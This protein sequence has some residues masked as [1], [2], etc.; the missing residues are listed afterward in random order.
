M[1]FT[2]LS[3]LIGGALAATLPI[4][5]HLLSKGAPKRQV[6]PAARFVRAKL[7]ANKRRLTLKRL[8]LLAVRVAMILLLGLTLSRPYFAH[9][10]QG[11][12]ILEARSQTEE[13][14]QA[15]Q[16][17][18]PA[19][20]I[21]IDTSVRMARV[22]NN[23]TLLE[24]ARVGALAILEQTASE[25]KIAI[26]D[27]NYDADGFLPDRVAARERLEKLAILPNGRSA[28]QT[29]REALRLLERA[30]TSGELFIF[31]DETQRSWPERDTQRVARSLTEGKLKDAVKLFFVD[32]GDD[33]YRNA[34]ITE[35]ALSSETASASSGLR[36]DVEVQRQGANEENLTLELLLFAQQ[37]LPEALGNDAIVALSQKALQRQTQ[38]LAFTE[39]RSKRTA[40]FNLSALPLGS[41]VG[42]ARL[43]GADALN[44]DDQR[45]FAVKF[46]EAAR[47][48]VVSTAPA[49]ET[50]LF[51]TEALAPEEERQSGRASFQFD[52]LPYAMTAQ[53]SQ[54]HNFSALTDAKL[55]EYSSVFLLDPP[56]LAPEMLSK[57]TRYV[58]H[59]GGLAVF[60]GPHAA[61][62]GAF[63]SPEAL[64]LLGAKPSSQGRAPN[65]DYALWP[66]SYEEPLL[67]SFRPY[68]TYD[69]PW[70]TLAISRFWYLT[71][72]EESNTT[73]VAEIR[74]RVNA[75]RQSDVK[76]VPGLIE[77]RLGEGLVAVMVT[78][79]SA[80]TASQNWNALTS[81]D[82][83]W[84]FILLVD[85]IA[86]RLA[87]HSS[88]I[89][90]YQLGENVLLRAPE[91]EQFQTATVITPEAERLPA[92]FDAQR[93][94]IKA[95]R[96]QTP[97]LYRVEAQSQ[98]GQNRF[99]AVYAVTTPPEQF[100][101]TRHSP[102]EWQN[103]WK[104]APYQDLEIDS[105]TQLAALRRNEEHEPY[106]ILV[107]ALACML[108]LETFLSNRFYKTQ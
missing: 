103:L 92:P 72:L 49:Q 58:E 3:L 32:L 108:L 2:T 78:P 30:G 76:G 57:L 89:L 43:V 90:N 18:A 102:Q 10:S 53:D 9:K 36:V 96:A 42:M 83:T 23:A 24:T 52:V 17:A 107:L 4:I 71:E 16:S 85:S 38:T 63:D 33:D 105:D 51:L 77:H 13:R 35:V 28:A 22:R 91:A 7:V 37:D 95:P 55:G 66:K 93:G 62:K 82:A 54:A 64:N 81:S 70:D 60:L 31:T 68:Q 75:S 74:S 67:A 106:A 97:G 50:S 79:I 8:I 44:I 5:I 59:G 14:E 41:C 6:F 101:L 45:V 87:W 94:V 99:S 1:I 48:L 34:S 39:G 84:V 69:I 26:L 27:G 15:E 29:T 19:T 21:I 46:A 12:P 73:V 56:D 61:T 98:R 100:E 65:W 20:I 104:D 47:A 40:T 11:A 86:R 80:D 25:S 88:S